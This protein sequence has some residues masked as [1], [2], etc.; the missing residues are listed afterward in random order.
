MRKSKSRP[1]YNLQTVKKLCSSGDIR[2]TK[3]VV[4]GLRNRGYMR[5][6]AHIKGLISNL[7][8]KDFRQSIELEKFQPYYGDV[9]VTFFEDEDWYVKFYIEED[10]EKKAVILLSAKYDGEPF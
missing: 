9:Y 7:S 2:I 1:S 3:T 8:P 4:R 6:Q 10:K 5:I